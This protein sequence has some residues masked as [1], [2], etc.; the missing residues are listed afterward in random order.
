M[1]AA[2]GKLGSVW[3]RSFGLRFGGPLARV[4]RRCPCWVVHHVAARG[5]GAPQSSLASRLR[6]CA[7]AVSSTSSRTPFRPRSRSRSSLRMRFIS[8]NRI[9]TFLRHDVFLLCQY[10]STFSKNAVRTL[11]FA[12]RFYGPGPPGGLSA[13]NA[14]RNAIPAARRR[15]EAEAGVGRPARCP[16]GE[17]TRCYRRAAATC[18]RCGDCRTLKR[19]RV[20]GRSRQRLELRPKRR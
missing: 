14:E 19:P 1:S 8:A 12:V 2:G 7:V 3:T 9:S 6:F 10:D 5:G 11:S 20:A 15:A 4:V 18:T 16:K 13:V 17:V